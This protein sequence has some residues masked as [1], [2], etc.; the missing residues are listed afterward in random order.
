MSTTLD[1]FLDGQVHI[2]QPHEG[3][4]AGADPV[5]LAASIPAEENHMILDVGAGVGVAMLCLAARVSG[6]RIIGLE[7]QREF[8]R[9]A[10][11]NIQLNKFQH[12]LE[13]IQGDL[14]LPPPRLAASS[15]THVMSNPPYFAHD[16]VTK[17]PHN[18]KAL[19][20]V[21]STCD[22]K[23]W[24]DFCVRMVQPKG[25]V[26]F[27][28]TADRLDDLVKHAS[29]RLGELVLFPLWPRAGKAAKRFLLRG[30]KNVEG[31]TTIAAGLILHDDSGAYSQS[32]QA[33]LRAGKS[34]DLR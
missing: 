33:I 30:R 25:T 1:K 15:F 12:R 11:H 13:I 7:M 4:R 32:A 24:V 29:V 8:V 19:S 18:S 26:S 17:S 20:N 23:I 31:P 10:S 2:V 6:C 34:L 14:L 21:E 28:Y 5:L 16:Q 27:I 22:L 9:L 3:Y